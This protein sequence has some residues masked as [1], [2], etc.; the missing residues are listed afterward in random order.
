[1]TPDMDEKALAQATQEAMRVFNGSITPYATWEAHL[2]AMMGSA[3]A[4]YLA[5]TARDGDGVNAAIEQLEFNAKHLIAEADLDDALFTL[6]VA[7]EVMR[8]T[9]AAL[10]ASLKAVPEVEVVKLKWHGPDFEDEYWAAWVGG[11]YTI[12]A[13]N[14][15]GRWLG[16]VGGYFETVEAAQA[17]AQSDFASRIRSCLAQPAPDAEVKP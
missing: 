13:Q 8:N 2:S 15:N 11:K 7:R 14:G 10:R 16:G 4:A 5:A 12:G 3:I 1:M 6:D 17:A 9:A